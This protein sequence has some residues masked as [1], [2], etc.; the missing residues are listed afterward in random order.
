MQ[1][2]WQSEEGQP[3]ISAASWSPKGK[4]IALGLESGDVLTFTPSNKDA[5]QKHIPPTS[6]QTPM[7]SMQWIGPGHTFRTV[8]C[9]QAQND[10][11]VH[12]IVTLD[13][14]VGALDVLQLDAGFSVTDR[15]PPS[16]VIFSLPRWNNEDSLLVIAGDAAASDFEVLGH[17]NGEWFQESSDNPLAV[18]MK[19]SFEENVLVGL[20]VDLT[21]GVP[22]MVGYM[23]DG[24]VQLW[25]MESPNPYPG[26]VTPSAVEAPQGV[27]ATASVSMPTAPASVAPSVSGGSTVA[28]SAMEQSVS[29]MSMDEPKSA[30]QESAPASAFSPPSFGQ[31]P[32]PSFGQTS[33]PSPFSPPTPSASSPF[34]QP[35]TPSAFGQTSTPSAF[36]QPSAPSVFG[37]PSGFGQSA[38]GQTSSNGSAF[39]QSSGNTSGFGQSSNNTSGFGQTSNPASAFGKPASGQ[40]GFGQSA[41]GQ[42]SA[43]AFGQT[44]TPAFGQTSAFGQPSFGSTSK[45]ATPG[46]FGSTGFGQTA[47]PA[48]FGQSA[49]PASAGK[50]FGAFANAGT[51]AFG[52]TSTPSTGGG[53]GAF[54][55]AGKSAFGQGGFGAAPAAP[56]ATPPRTSPPPDSPVDDSAMDSMGSLGLGGSNSPK[57]DKPAAG[58]LFGNATPSAQQDKP[59]GSPFGAP[60]SSSP[61]GSSAIKPA[62]GFGAFSGFQPTGGAF[63]PKDN[64]EAPK[65]TFGAG[66]FAG[67]AKP[68]SGFGSTGFGQTATP[69]SASGSGFG[70]SSFGKPAFG[71]SA[72]GQPGFGQPAASGK[73]AFG[74]SSFGTAPAT[75]GFGA[76]ASKPASLVGTP[77]AKEEDKGA[78]KPATGGFGAFA[79]RTASFT[80]S[81]GESKAFGGFGTGGSIG[82]QAKEEKPTTPKEEKPVEVAVKQE[83][84][85]P[86][87]P[88]P[89]P[90]PVKSEE[91]DSTPVK[92]EE[93]SPSPT[94]KPATPSE[95]PATPAKG[96]EPASVPATPLTPETPQ[97]KDVKPKSGFGFNLQASPSPFTT[98]AFGQPS[99]PTSSYIKP[100]AGFGSAGVVSPGSPFANPGKAST[101]TSAFGSAFKKFETPKTE[102]TAAPTFGAPSIPGL[103]KSAFPTTPTGPTAAKE[104]SS[105]GFAAF[106][107]NTSPFKTPPDAPKTSFKDML[108]GKDRVPEPTKP[109]VFSP[110]VEKPKTPTETR[111]SAFPPSPA[112]DEESMTPAGTPVSR[113]PVFKPK[114]EKEGG[115]SKALSKTKS[116]S[117]SSMGSFVD[118]SKEDVS[119]EGEEEEPDEEGEDF[120]SDLSQSEGDSADELPS[121]TPSKPP[122]RERSAS[123]TPKPPSRVV[124]SD[125]EPP[126]DEFDEEESDEG[127]EEEE[128]EDVTEES[129]LSTIPE[130]S[131]TPPESPVK[132]PSKASEPPGSIS[133]GLRPPSSGIPFNLGLGKA[134]ASRPVRSSP[135]A[136]AYNASDSES[137]DKTEKKPVAAPQ[138]K[139]ATPP[140]EAPPSRTGTPPLLSNFGFGG[141]SRQS[142]TPSPTNVPP[143]ASRS[144][145]PAVP[146]TTAPIAST[147]LA[148]IASTP[149]APTTKSVFGAFLSTPKAGE[150]SPSASGSAS[151][152]TPSTPFGATKPPATPGFPSVSSSG[153]FGA[154]KAPAPVTPSTPSGLFGSA[155]PPSTTPSGPNLMNQL[156]KFAMPAP[157]PSG[158]IHPP[159]PLF[160][161]AS[162]APPPPRPTTPPQEGMQKE[163]AEL[164]TSIERE[165]NQL[166]ELAAEANQQLRKLSDPV[167]GSRRKED[168]VDAAK[169]S[170]GDLALFGRTLLAFSK[171][172]T[173]L[174]AARDKERQLVKELRAS[175]L[176]ANTRKEE[177]ARFSKA[178]SDPEFAKML[179]TRTLG[180]EHLE[181]Q[182]NLRRNLRIVRDR[183]QALE[184]NLNA[185]KKKLSQQK[186]GK[187]SIRP[188]TL[189]VLN[190]T[191][192]NI[193]LAINNDRELIDSLTARMASVSFGEGR[194]RAAKLKDANKRDSRL[195]D[196]NP[197]PLNVTPNVAVT[198]A[199]ALNA[200]RSAARLKRVLLAARPEPLLN[201]TAAS[202]PAPPAVFQTPMKPGATPRTPAFDPKDAMWADFGEDKFNPQTPTPAGRRGAGS[203]VRRHQPSPAVKKIPLSTPSPP[204]NFSW[205]P[206]P[207]PRAA[208]SGSGGLPVPIVKLT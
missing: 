108:K 106:S 52:Q 126:S 83:P 165:L 105:G 64:K 148:P 94:P 22:T 130:E 140:P 74:Q 187:V 21:D 122:P 206:L 91:A 128:I 109:A 144:V 8:Y 78:S 81:P 114:E 183:V 56:Q 42:T 102:A 13:T 208:T 59:A 6:S 35:A 171:D 195:P 111:K 170:L 133:S 3:R 89:A 40:S 131:S 157:A 175:M 2:G 38:F 45:P 34:G 72:F 192:R 125:E 169:W 96:P 110:A 184:D 31:T 100:A 16:S 179:K 39:G 193:D 164:V 135:L 156:G 180:P 17:A 197:R 43:P 71:Q 127:D 70:Q 173:E 73:P 146:A 12:H 147:P 201:K 160:V 36:G 60:A 4:Q 153:F 132:R 116:G 159:V 23:D 10:E 196:P 50:G 88:P 11:P 181:T 117:L 198:T 15:Y 93:R 202:A 90:T 77:A 137:E 33:S 51:S 26:L 41:F 107:N 166:G 66:A 79:S 57:E 54:S 84:V 149:L 104:P 101:S 69:G 205:G 155:I 20:A 121:T 32:T 167:P 152:S 80:T 103:R 190:R 44:S 53:F 82:E 139:E 24:T 185:L 14:R 200:E 37:K 95:A 203:G 48:G 189:D 98:P 113:P 5:P 115:S 188:P 176:K 25:A 85:S 87:A 99:T 142:A 168:L 129:G 19:E 172:L 68:A 63:A 119:E 151:P 186:S 27:E 47:Q 143:S 207:P 58:G 134:P 18:P 177:I 30:V 150:P 123:T 120:L 158:S 46:G 138:G 204:P 141:K 182:T 29:G 174:K 62:S 67:M 86:I 1:G 161:K 191:Y 154:A 124:D 163:C 194:S 199:A 178:Q 55:G 75:G 65:P 28:P 76:F 136:N 118:V 7:V 61:F 162:Q 97:E 9:A 92:V 145:S 49:Q 112:K